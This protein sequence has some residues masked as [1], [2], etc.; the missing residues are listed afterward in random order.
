LDYRED[1]PE[2]RF[3]AGDGEVVGEVIRVVAGVLTLP[4]FWSLRPAW[5]DL[6]QEVLRRILESLRQGRFDATR[7]F[8]GY[9]HGV[10]RF[11]ALDAM[12]RKKR[13][14]V[15]GTSDVVEFA[16]EPAGKPDAEDRT[17]ARQLARIALDKASPDCRRLFRDYFFKERNY[18][19]IA[20]SMGVP[21][22]TV[23][24]RLF[25]CLASAQR[26]MG[27]RWQGGEA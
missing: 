18:R 9:A 20:E 4:R 2:G 25:R 1:S 6:H 12:S 13:D 7:D 21:V 23:K 3:L 24:S 8:L 26:T 27:K 17:M 11:T 10:A 5:A 14:S 16:A 22:G 19:E 15:V